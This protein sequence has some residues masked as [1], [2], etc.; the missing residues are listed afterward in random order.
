MKGSI[1]MKCSDTTETWRRET[2]DEVGAAARNRK[3]ERKKERK[4]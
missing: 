1:N 3:G 4:K 2:T